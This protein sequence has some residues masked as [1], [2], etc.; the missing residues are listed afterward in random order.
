LDKGQIGWMP[1]EGG[2]A[3]VIPVDRTVMEVEATPG[4]GNAVSPDGTTIVLSGG[5]RSGNALFVNIFTV[6]IAGGQPTR[7]TDFRDPD[8]RFPCWS[9]D[10]RRVAFVARDADRKTTGP[11]GKPGSLPAAGPLVFQIY[12][13]SPDGTGLRKVTSEA[14]RVDW[15]TVAWSP[16]G[17]WIGF[18]TW[19]KTLSLI[20]AEGGDSRVVADL[21][22]IDSLLVPG[23]GRLSHSEIAWSPDGKELAF[24]FD[25]RLWTVGVG[26]GAVTEIRTGLTGVRAIH[27]DWSPDGRTIALTGSEGGDEQLWLMEDFTHLVKAPE[28]K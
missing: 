12:V 9:P 27:L 3:T 20:P 8:T 17:K 1:A 6:P 26:G 21:R 23:V 19:D 7:L 18:F 16:D 5:H 2:E 10:G 14:H 15:S 25:G 13:V 22:R 24:S 28:K 11:T 4:G